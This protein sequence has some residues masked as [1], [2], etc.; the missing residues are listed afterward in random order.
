MKFFK[1]SYKTDRTNGK[2]CYNEKKRMKVS[3]LGE[4]LN[5]SMNIVVKRAIDS[6]NHVS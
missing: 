3:V 1:D 6:V 5:Q 2:D 4:K